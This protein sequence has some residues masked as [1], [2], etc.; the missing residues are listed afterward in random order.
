[1]LASGL[2]RRFQRS[3]KVGVS[4]GLHDLRANLDAQCWRLIAQ[5]LVERL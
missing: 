1:M 3:A 5:L 4:R 2:S